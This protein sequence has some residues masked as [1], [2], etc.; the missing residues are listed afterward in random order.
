MCLDSFVTLASKCGHKQLTK[1][2]LDVTFGASWRMIGAL[3]RP[4]LPTFGQEISEAFER[5]PAAAKGNIK[6]L[7]LLGLPFRKIEK[8]RLESNPVSTGNQQSPKRGVLLR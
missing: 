7:S 1:D 8:T 6:E 4:C 2:G 3:G 5:I